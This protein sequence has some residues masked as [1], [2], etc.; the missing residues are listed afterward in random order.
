MQRYIAFIIILIGLAAFWFYES[1]YDTQNICEN[2]YKTNLKTTMKN[3]PKKAT[4]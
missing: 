3:N 2:Y 4:K 1:N